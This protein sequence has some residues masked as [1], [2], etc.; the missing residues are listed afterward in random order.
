M[1][2]LDPTPATGERESRETPGV[3]ASWLEGRDLE[4]F[5]P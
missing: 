4:I 3:S 2:G 1:E 5:P